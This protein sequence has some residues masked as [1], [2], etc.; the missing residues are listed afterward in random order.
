MLV[1][2]QGQQQLLVGEGGDLGEVALD[3]GALQLHLLLQSLCSAAL[4]HL[5]GACL[6]QGSFCH[7]PLL[8]HHAHLDHN[9]SS[10]TSSSTRVH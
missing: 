9:P 3:L 5:F 2:A 1:H 10:A 4:L 6:L 7:Q 8:F